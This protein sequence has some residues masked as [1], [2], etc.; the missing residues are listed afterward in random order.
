MRK[1]S[2]QQ[3]VQSR[4]DQYNEQVMVCL[5]AFRDTFNNCCSHLDREQSKD[6]YEIVHTSERKADDLRRELEDMMYTEAVFPES[7]GD[8]LGLV[9]AMDK[10]PNQAESTVRMV[11]NQHIELP[12]W[13]CPKLMKLADVSHQSARTM[14][15]GVEKVFSN[16]I[17]ATVTVGKIDLLES[18]ADRREE[19]L[20]DDIFSSDLPDLQKIL[21]RDL[22]THISAIADRTENVGDRIRLMVAKRS[23]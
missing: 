16:Y 2:K 4:I 13:L 19:A 15:D 1:F 18:E 11:L 7:R 23:V 5:D 12:D 21:L 17:D 8:I 20:I 3:K 22:V 6:S 14:I 9:E 10:V